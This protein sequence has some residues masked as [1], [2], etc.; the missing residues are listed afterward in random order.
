MFA[1][2]RWGR[3][4]SDED[5]LPPEIEDAHAELIASYEVFQEAVPE[6]SPG[7][8]DAPWA[9]YRAARPAHWTPANPSMYRITG[10]GFDELKRRLLKDAYTSLTTVRLDENANVVEGQQTYEAWSRDSR[11]PFFEARGI[12][13]GD[14]YWTNVNDQ[15]IHLLGKTLEDRIDESAPIDADPPSK[16]EDRSSTNELAY[17]V[18]LDAFVFKIFLKAKDANDQDVFLAIRNMLDFFFGSVHQLDYVKHD[19]MEFF[20]QYLGI[21]LEA[22]Y[23]FFELSGGPELF[24]GD[25]DRCYAGHRANWVRPDYITIRIQESEFDPSFGTVV[26]GPVVT[27]TESLSNWEKTDFNRVAIEPYLSRLRRQTGQ[28]SMTR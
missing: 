20:S 2:S 25:L 13:K 19:S 21:E 12:P 17:R 15:V 7:P 23:E 26:N 24:L 9:T 10:V 28:L 8:N 6:F 5:F 3:S 27:Y 18:E 16:S 11:K 14:F 4:Y 22:L 1:D